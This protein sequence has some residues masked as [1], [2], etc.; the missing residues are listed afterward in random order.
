MEVS[1]WLRLGRSTRGECSAVT[2]Y[3]GGLVGLDM[4]T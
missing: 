4:D 2:N 1:V 3:V